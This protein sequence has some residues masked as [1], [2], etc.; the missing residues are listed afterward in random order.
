LSLFTFKKKCHFRNYYATGSSALN[1]RENQ[2]RIILSP[3]PTVGSPVTLVGFQN[4]PP[5]VTF[6]NELVTGPPGTGD[7]AD[8]YLAPDSTH[9]YLRGSLGIDS[10]NNYSIGAAV[11]NSALFIADEL[12][13]GMRWS[14]ATPIKIIY[15]KEVN[16]TNRTTLDIYQSPPMSEIVYWF[17]QLSINMYG[18]A[19]VKTIAQ[20]TN[21]SIDSVLPTYCETEHG[22]EQ[23]AVATRDGSGLSPENR[24]TTWA[25]A[26]VLYNVQQ[27]ASWFPSFERALP[28]VNGIRMKG[29][30]ISNVLSY[31]GYIN[32][33][34]FSIIS[35]NYNGA[36]SVMRQ[37][38]W[39]LL[40]TLK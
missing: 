2:F 35:N 10:A 13:Q 18:E 5:S 17:E 12:R 24:I 30:F 36:T 28:V 23:T 20:A 25:I 4:L 9:G 31:S 7:L 29:G 26:R 27:R 15:Q 34:V 11:P 3:G 6:T 8:V 33:Q 40:D 39:S 16:P 32:K 38:I 37:K 14:D 1:W 19:L 21:S 22:I